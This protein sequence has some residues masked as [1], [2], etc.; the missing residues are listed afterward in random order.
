M[1]LY[2]IMVKFAQMTTLSG[3][4]PYGP[5]G[6]EPYDHMI[7]NIPY[8]PCGLKSSHTIEF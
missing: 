2:A 3:P 7:H 4:G 6:P 8:G 5:N 1:H